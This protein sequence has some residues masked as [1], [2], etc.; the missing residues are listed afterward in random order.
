MSS[1]NYDAITKTLSSPPPPTLQ[2]I[3][4]TFNAQEDGDKELLAAI[5]RA[6][7]AEELR[8]AAVASLQETIMQLQHALAQAS[9]LIPSPH[10][11][12]RRSQPTKSTRRKTATNR[13]TSR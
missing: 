1:G 8:V 10:T 13:S 2:E 7:E 12:P 4:G 3:L 6:K 11:P 5:V 9:G